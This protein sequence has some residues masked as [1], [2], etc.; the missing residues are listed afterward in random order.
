MFA[1]TEEMVAE[2]REFEDFL[3]TLETVL[4]CG[5]T[6]ILASEDDL[7]R[8]SFKVIVGALPDLAPLVELELGT[9]IETSKWADC[10]EINLMVM[11]GRTAQDLSQG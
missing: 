1:K 2:E 3:L 6:R 5:V 11:R 10:A 8:K 9:R 7:A 4:F